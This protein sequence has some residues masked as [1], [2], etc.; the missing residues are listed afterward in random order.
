MAGQ[1]EAPQFSPL[2]P[3]DP[4]QVAGYRLVARLGSGGMGSVYLSFTPGGQ[5]VAVKVVRGEFA[6]DQAFRRRFAHEVRAARQVQGIYTVPVLDSNTEGAAP[7]LAT[8]FVAGLS[9]HEVVTEHGPLPSQTVLLLVGGV[10]EALQSIHATGIVHRDLKPG[11]VLLSADGPKVIDFGIARAADVTALTGTDVRVGTPAFMAPEQ[12]TGTSL[13]PAAD[14]FTLGI[15]AHYAATG[16][17]PFGEGAAHTMMYRMV[18]EEPD[19]AAAPETLRGLIGACLAKDPAARPTPAQIIEGCRALSPGQ[20][21]QRGESWLPPS[22]AAAVAV[23]RNATLPAPE[24]PLGAGPAPATPPPATPPAMPPLAQPATPPPGP[25]TPP[26]STPP[27]VTT[28]GLPAGAAGDPGQQARGRRVILML[29]ATAV[30]AAVAG[31]VLAVKFFGTEAA[32][33]NPEAGPTEETSRTDEEP[34]S[35]ET[36]ADETS[37]DQS[38]EDPPADDQAP[39]PGVEQDPDSAYVLV[40]EGVDLDIVAPIFNRDTSVNTSGRCVGGNIIRVDLDELTVDT[41]FRA[42][43]LHPSDSDELVYLYCEGAGLIDQGIEFQAQSF[44]G[45]TDNPDITAEECYEAAHA[46]TLPHLIPVDDIWE[47]RTLRENTGLCFETSEDNVVLLWINR[48][49]PDPHNKDLRTYLT[50]A[51]QWSPR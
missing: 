18:Q 34:P 40:E 23:R 42:V 21:L 49:T 24:A 17:H 46:P 3:Q 30:V 4:R 33:T 29:A 47:D 16:G 25:P 32:S 38:D 10:A 15:V 27:L 9:L 26:P 51:R 6:D 11:N 45:A 31:A 1:P 41:G 50:T 48:V 2:G 8:A 35:Q 43:G 12:I 36:D 22:V 13:T 44:V 39:D 20:T 19:L 28:G 14:V 37:T 7:W 5:P